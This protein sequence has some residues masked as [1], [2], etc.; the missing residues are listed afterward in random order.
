VFRKDFNVQADG[1][2]DH[3]WVQESDF[4][5]T[6]QSDDGLVEHAGLLGQTTEQE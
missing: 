1:V 2:A 4:I 6:H 3:R 5:Q